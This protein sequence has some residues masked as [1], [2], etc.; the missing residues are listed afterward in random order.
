MGKSIGKKV[1]A[2]VGG[3]GILLVVSIFLNL[4]AL[5]TIKEQNDRIA[6][7]I[8]KYE[9]LVHN[10]DSSGLA[11]LEEEF[12]F[13]IGKSA[14]KIRGTVVFDF[15]LAG[16]GI[17]LVIVSALIV[18]KSIGKPAKNASVRL[19]SIVDKI[20][21]N[22][23][24]LTERIEVKTK[25]EI[26]QLA[27]GIN[28]FI[29]SLQVLM[30]KLQ[31]ES[32]NMLESANTVTAQVDDSNR[33]ALNVSS[34][35]EELA[36]SLEEIAATLDQLVDGSRTILDRIQ[37]MNDS[38]DSGNVTVNDIK[39]RAID[40]HEETIKSKEHAMEVL[41]NIGTQLEEAVQESRNVEKINELTNNI[42][43][44]ASQT[45]LLALNAS[46]E[47]ARAGD[48]GRGFA[49]VA[50]EI[51]SLAEN[52]RETAN[53][54]QNISGLVTNAVTMLADNAKEMLN[55]V[56]TDVI[57]DYDGF[58]EIVNQY[59]ADA[60]L[61][62]QILEGFAEEAAVINE[63]MKD[64]STSMD[65]VSSTVGESARAVASVAEDAALLVGA[66][67]NI[68]EETE[69]TNRI[70]EELQNEVKRFERV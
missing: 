40:M 34:A 50:D 17:I 20:E 51:R 45:N 8:Q 25:D 30:Q 3:I 62:S 11:A 59:Q 2:M 1:F 54:I 36:A 32:A 55:F 4:A 15:I 29:E 67:S 10:N 61:M 28:N 19:G 41:K 39:V 66:I 27:N 26:G 13:M 18:N 6:S 44:I 16:A 63:T 35:T 46:I 22:K 60:D 14:T 43:N 70:S 33:S 31:V 64:M 65:D 58:V 37:T 49:V 42:L 53:D 7:D 56:G 52:S 47:A 38:A 68:Q 12:E 69:N 23:G 57:K 9:E 5:G 21:N 24:D 48:A